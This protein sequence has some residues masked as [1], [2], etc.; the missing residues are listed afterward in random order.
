MPPSSK[1]AQ[2]NAADDACGA[3]AVGATRR[4]AAAIENI[5]TQQQSTQPTHTA[6]QLNRH[7]TQHT[8]A[9]T[10][11]HTHSNSHTHI[12]THVTVRHKEARNQI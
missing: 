9:R 6:H 4:H 12:Q 10:H 3:K 11:T 7:T 2:K 5:G 8:R 1:N